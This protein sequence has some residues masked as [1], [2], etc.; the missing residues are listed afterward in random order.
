MPANS[1]FTEIITT[2]I[3]NRSRELADNV[4]NHIPL[5]MKLNERGNIKLTGGGET[6]VQE[7]DLA[8]SPNFMYYSGYERFSVNAPDSFTAAEY[9]WKQAA[10]AV[11]MSGLERRQNMGRE[12][13]IDL[14]QGRIT[15]AMRTMRNNLATGIA[16]DGTGTSGKQVTGLQAAVPD[17]PTTGTY[18]GINRANFAAWQS[19]IQEWTGTPSASNV[20][21]EMNTLWLACIRGMDAPDLIVAGTTYFNYFWQSLQAIQRIGSSGTGTGGFRSLM[22]EGPQGLAPIIYDSTISAT[23]LYM[24]N[25]TYLFWRVHPQANMTPLPDRNPTDQDA[26]VVPIIWQGNLTTSNSARQGVLVNLS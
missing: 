17:D 19:Q 23:R 24:L 14:M 21:S 20:Q 4:S 12:Q 10:D 15:N 8:E 7:L 1:N 22:F 9:S 18:G 3:K 26:I 2:T 5:L 6:I 25:T 16:S 11:T 13:M